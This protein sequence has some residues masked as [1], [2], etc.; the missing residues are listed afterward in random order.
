VVTNFRKGGNELQEIFSS[1]NAGIAKYR[2]D[3]CR[4]LWPGNLMEMQKAAFIFHFEVNNVIPSEIYM[5][6]KLEEPS[7]TFSDLTSTWM[8]EVCQPPMVSEN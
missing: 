1:Y 8:M 5:T 6:R 4:G 2:C 3:A 7:R